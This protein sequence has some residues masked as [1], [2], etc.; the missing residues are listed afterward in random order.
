[1][2]AMAVPLT[3]VAWKCPGTRSVLCTMMLICSVPIVTPVMPPTKPNTKTEKTSELKPG[4]CQGARRSHSNM[5]WVNPRRRM[6]S[7]MPAGT[8][9]PWIIEASTAMY[10]K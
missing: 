5:P 8:V 9:K 7:S 4:S 3:T 2:K 10:M 6:P 1:M